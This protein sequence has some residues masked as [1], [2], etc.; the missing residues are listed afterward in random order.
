MLGKSNANALKNT[1]NSSVRA[2]D[3]SEPKLSSRT[4]LNTG[5]FGLIHPHNF[6]DNENQNDGTKSKYCT[7]HFF[8]IVILSFTIIHIR[9]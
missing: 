6:V 3:N 2:T 4:G 8:S 7:S 1:E 9:K 5:G